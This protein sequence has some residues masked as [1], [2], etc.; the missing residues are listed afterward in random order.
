MKKAALEGVDAHDGFSLMAE[1]LLHHQI[2]DVLLLDVNVAALQHRYRESMQI[3]SSTVSGAADICD[4][5]FCICD[6]DLRALPA[7]LLST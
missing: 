2:A 1:A 5:T 3:Q 6:A 7:Q 4:H